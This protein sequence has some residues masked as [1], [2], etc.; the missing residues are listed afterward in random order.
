MG[1]FTRRQQNAGHGMTVQWTP[2]CMFPSN[3]YFFSLISLCGHHSPHNRKETHN[4]GNEREAQAAKLREKIQRLRNLPCQCHFF[5]FLFFSILAAMRQRLSNPPIEK[6]RNK[7]EVWAQQQ[8]NDHEM[9]AQQSL[10]DHW[11]IVRPIHKYNKNWPDN[12]CCAPKFSF[13]FSLFTY[14]PGL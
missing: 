6:K 10:R 5:H 8:I 4:V 3:L 1:T 9:A 14:C 13:L 12:A 11:S 7:K 2:P